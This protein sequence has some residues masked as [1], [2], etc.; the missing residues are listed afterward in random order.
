M[1]D[2]QRKDYKGWLPSAD[3]T[4]GPKNC[5]LRADNLVLDD[6]GILS[7]R[8]GSAVLHGPLADLD[9]HSLYSTVMTGTR[10]RM[11]GAGAN[12]YA[13]GVSLATVFAGAGDIIFGSA[14]G[15]ILMA[16][17]T[18][19]K[20]YD[21][22]T[23]R[24]WGLAAPTTVPTIAPLAS[25]YKAFGEFDV[26]GGDYANWHVTLG[27]GD[28]VAGSGGGADTALEITT[29]AAGAAEFH[30]HF[31]TVNFTVYDAAQTG[32]DDDL[33]Q[34]LVYITDPFVLNYLSVW[35]GVA[36]GG[37]TPDCF[38]YTWDF[39]VNPK[40]QQGW[41]LLEV[42][43]GDFARFGNDPARGWT[44]VVDTTFVIECSEPS[45]LVFD[46]VN[47]R[48]GN[49]SPITG[50]TKYCYCSVYNS[51]EYFAISGKSP[52]TPE[53]KLTRQGATITI[54]MAIFATLDAQVNEI[55]L[56]RFSTYLGEFMRVK[57][58]NDV[59]AH[60]AAGTDMVESDL[61]SDADVLI[62]NLPL[63]IDNL[64]PPD[65]IVDIAGPYYM[66]TMV[67]T[68]TELH[69]SRR[70]NPDS[71]SAGQ[72]FKAA[73]KDETAL[74]VRQALGGLYIGTTKDI[75]RLD[76]DG[77]EYPDGTINFKID[78]CNLGNPPISNAVGQEGNALVYLASDGW[79]AFTGSNSE[80]F[81]GDL[82]LLFRGETRH[83][84]S[85]ANLA[86]GRFRLAMAK[87][88]MTAITPEGAD[89]VSS[90]VLHRK[91]FVNDRWYRHTYP[92]AWRSIFV[93]RDGTLIAGDTA[94]YIYQL[95]IGTPD[96]TTDIPVVIWTIADDDNLSRN[97]KDPQDYQ[98]LYNTSGEQVTINLHLDGAA[99]SSMTLSPGP[100]AG[101]VLYEIKINTL[102]VFRQVQQRITGS[103]HT[104]KWLESTICY[105]PR[106]ELATWR[107]N[108][109]ETPSPNRRRFTGLSL[110][111]DTLGAAAA[112]TPYLD[113][114]A[115]A[116]V[117]VTTSFPISV[118]VNFAT[119]VVGRD[120]WASVAKATGF[121]LYKIEP[122]ISASLPP[123]AFFVNNRPETPSPNR[124]RFTGIN[125][126]IDTLGAAATVT[127]YLDGVA[128]AAVNVTTA[129]PLSRQVNFTA[130]QVGRDLW[131]SVACATGFEL[132]K[133]EPIVSASLPPLVCFVENRPE[134]PSGH[135]KRF[136]G[137]NVVIDTLGAAATIT[138]ILDG[139]AQ[140]PVN[141][142]T[143]NPLPQ[144]INFDAVVGYDLWARVVK[145]TGFEL[146][147]VDPIII[148]NLPV[149]MRGR[150]PN[151]NFD[152]PGAKMCSSLKFRVCTLG[153]LRT[154]TPIVD[155]TAL[156]TFTL[157]SGAEPDTYL[158]QFSPLQMATDIAFSVDG[159]IELYEFGPVVA[160]K[161]PLPRKMWDTGSGFAL[162]NSDF[163][164]IAEV[165]L[166]ALAPAALTIVPYFDDTA[167]FAQTVPVEPGKV[168][169]Y[170][171]RMPRGFRGSVPRFVITCAGGVEF[172]PYWLEVCW[173]GTKS[174]SQK[175]RR[176]YPS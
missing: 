125:L 68:A 9:V 26:A 33:F 110:V 153:A 173:R 176:V 141:V 144:I 39:I 50:N 38:R 151:S 1:K 86:T 35:V 74:W 91:D 51:G 57:V 160:Y 159:D 163:N 28:H 131:A 85:P 157:N 3:A 60:R 112:V 19:K 12:V 149:K 111:I 145:G 102:G 167:F 104:F 69:V 25:D 32:S 137:L 52:E 90:V 103:F 18:T 24:N 70:N 48:G 154:F 130:E 42:K 44:T 129:N 23:V 171:V 94:G 81:A 124:R 55:W 62:I 147:K 166:K 77:A 133:I 63:Q 37:C 135:R 87:G 162:D 65:S 46:T 113:G 100:V 128:L 49:A 34:V 11:A 47:F 156:A 164:W 58:I 165:V 16:R 158:Y 89:T 4:N 71:F 5:L 79:R 174:R 27:T 41:N 31:A 152:Y 105:L 54:P 59:A 6:L 78:H 127:P 13:N 83:G 97:R 120:L 148:E 115:Q 76:G 161:Q 45:V 40:P 175:P 109:P 7:L 98:A 88:L 170:H 82:G 2:L 132:Y 150:I 56:Y 123:L 14:K 134:V 61:L 117:N 8:K 15:Q 122:I 118:Q 93:E 92:A 10:Y 106:A 114:V 172:T 53:T 155:G 96:V 22:T 80:P 142:T 126:V 64:P 138:P 72:V 36:A 84:V 169:L 95:D 101:Q 107:Q 116:A 168:V 143:A 140:A 30:K 121:E 43:R 29:D 66:R 17:S 73:S 67:L 20:R 119:E 21:G 139:V 146:Y 99:G 108:R 75:Y 136:A